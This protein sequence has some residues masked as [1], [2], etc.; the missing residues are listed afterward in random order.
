MNDS[1]QHG[2]WCVPP[3]AHV[4]EVDD[5][6][7]GVGRLCLEESEKDSEEMTKIKQQTCW[8]TN[9]PIPTLGIDGKLVI[10]G[11]WFTKNSGDSPQNQENEV[12]SYRQ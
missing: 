7:P 12:H 9:L 1:I 10:R 11:V 8:L 3:T 5:S 6:H 2:A 4:Q